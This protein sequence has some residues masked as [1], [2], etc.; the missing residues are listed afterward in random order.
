MQVTA[1]PRTGHTSRTSTRFIA[2]LET[3]AQ[4]AALLARTAIEETA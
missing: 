3:S 1:L 4:R 2:A